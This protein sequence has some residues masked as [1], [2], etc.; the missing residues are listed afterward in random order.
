[1]NNFLP[2]LRSG[3]WSD[4]GGRHDM[5]DTHICITDLAKSF[6]DGILREEAVSFYGVSSLT[7]YNIIS[8]DIVLHLLMLLW[9]TKNP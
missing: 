4:I 8:P 3:E 1:M 2:A 5:E 6:G 7:Y 9:S